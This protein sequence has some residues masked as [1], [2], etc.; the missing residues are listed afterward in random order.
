[1]RI[2]ICYVDDEHDNY[3]SSFLS[4][5]DWCEYS[6]IN[7]DENDDFES[8]LN[9]I[10][11]S[12]CNI[13]LLD[14]KLYK[15]SNASSKITGQELELLLADKLPFMFSIV[16]SQN[17]DT[18]KLNYIMKYKTTKKPGANYFDESKEYYNRTLLPILIFAKN[19]INRGRDSF[20]N[21]L[22]KEDTIDKLMLENIKDIINVKNRISIT[23][24][25]VD[26]IVKALGQ[27]SDY[28]DKQE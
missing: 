17:E 5:I 13:V 27:I 20:T 23:K 6:D 15:E 2:K 1:M 9:K 14:S 18:N 3:L 28:E 24:E 26:K 8:L 25:D 12:Q 22:E 19:K 11:L 7:V 4:N 16:V 21:E 10:S